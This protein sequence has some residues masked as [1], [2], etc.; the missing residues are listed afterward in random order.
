[1][2]AAPH[3]ILQPG[4]AL[5]AIAASL[6]ALVPV[7]DAPRTR[8]RAPRMADFAVWADILCTDRSRYM[9]GP[10]TRDEAFLEFGAMTGVWL[11]RGFGA[12]TMADRGDDSALG[13]VCLNMEPSDREPELG[14]F[15][16]AAAEGRGLAHEAA[17]VARDW[18]KAQGLSSLVSY[19]DPANRRSVR[20]AERLGARRDA[21]AETAFDGTPD[22]G[23]AVFRHWGETRP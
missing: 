20:L 11:L 13:F 22:A 18:A 5:P 7:L 19:I 8:L 1:M 12:W 6:A 15:V 14:F 16:S 17:A 21:Q 4:F 3:E 10:S 9:D 2:T 23:V